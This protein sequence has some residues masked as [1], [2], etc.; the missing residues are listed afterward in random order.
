MDEKKMISENGIVEGYLEKQ[1][2]GEEH[3][4]RVRQTVREVTWWPKKIAA[5]VRMLPPDKPRR[6]EITV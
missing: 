2:T 6:I 4:L 1:E 5:L 3:I